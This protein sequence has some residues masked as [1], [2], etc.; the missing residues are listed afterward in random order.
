MDDY[1]F[2]LFGM[3][4]CAFFMGYGPA[5]PLQGAML[6]EP[7]HAYCGMAGNVNA[8]KI[9]LIWMASSHLNHLLRTGHGGSACTMNDPGGAKVFGMPS[10]LRRIILLAEEDIPNS[11]FLFNRLNQVF[12]ET[13]KK[14]TNPVSWRCWMK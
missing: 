13:Q 3:T 9:R 2:T 14:S 7:G 10:S 1:L 6:V 8:E 4:E 5:W 11:T 12:E